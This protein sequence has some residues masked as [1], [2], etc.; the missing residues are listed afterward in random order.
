M[1]STGPKLDAVPDVSSATPRTTDAGTAIEA[2]NLH[3]LVIRR[4]D[5]TEQ[6][7]GPLALTGTWE[8]Q[9]DNVK[10]AAISEA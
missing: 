9:K 5:L 2:A 6:P 4:L 1:Q 7:V 3:L 10:L 8:N